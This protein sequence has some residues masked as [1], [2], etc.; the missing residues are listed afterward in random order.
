M[1]KYEETSS[2]HK[3]EDMLARAAANQLSCISSNCHDIVH[4]VGNLKDA[5]MWTPKEKKE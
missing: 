4:D 2:H 1:R 3:S 5:P